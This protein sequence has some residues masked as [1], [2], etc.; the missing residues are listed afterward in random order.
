M[1]KVSLFLIVIGLIFLVPTIIL[2]ITALFFPP[3]TPN[4]LNWLSILIVFVIVL[5][6]VVGFAFII[7]GLIIT[8]R[9]KE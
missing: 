8:K 2:T 6:Y 4:Q 9:D 1:G 3:F 5:L 7:L